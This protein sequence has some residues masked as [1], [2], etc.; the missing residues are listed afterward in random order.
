M[1]W[2]NRG[3]QAMFDIVFRGATAPTNF[4]VALV[5]SATTPTVDTNTF[6]DLTEIT[7]GNGYTAGGA[8][9]DRNAT[10]FDSLVENDTDDRAELQIIDITWTASGGPIPASGSAIDHAILTDDNVTQSAREVW[11]FWD[12]DGPVTVSDGQP[13]TLQNLELRG[14]TV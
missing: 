8:Q 2:T 14:A 4:Y 13:L 6:A 7:A 10:D 11:A 1:A 12:L 3:A 9:L 5:T